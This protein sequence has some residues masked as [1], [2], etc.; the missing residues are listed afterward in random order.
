MKLKVKDVN[1][2]TGGPLIVILNYKDAK[3]LDIHSGDRVL[4]KK[5]RKEIIAALNVSEISRSI[6]HKEIGLLEE[7][8][9][10]LKIKKGEEL[11]LKPTHTPAS[12]EFI[13]KKLDG[14]KLSKKEIKIIVKDMTENDLT[15]VELAYFVSAC[16]KNR[17]SHDEVENLTKAVL[18]N[19]E[20]IKLGKKIIA[21]KHCLGGI[22]NNRTTMLITPI[23]AAAGLTIAKSSSRSITSAAGTADTMEVLSKIA[24]T[25]E[26]IKKIV[27]KANGC[28]IWGGAMELAG[29]DDKLIKVRYPLRLDPEGLMISSILAKK[30]SVGST[31]VLIDIPIGETAKINSKKKAKSLKRKF[32]H[33]GKRLGMN[34]KV[35]ITD[36]SQPIGNGIGPNLE[37][38]DVLYILRRDKKAPKDLEKKSIMMADKI[39]K[40]TKTKASAKIILESGL[41][42]TKMKEII[43][44]QN[45]KSSIK[46]EDIELAKYSYNVKSTRRGKVSFID[47]KKITKVARIAGAP[48]DKR[49]GVYLYK[50]LKTKVKK[51]EILYTI[52]SDSEDKLKYAK[53]I[54]KDSVK[55]S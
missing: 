19:G 52:Y 31:H 26:K 2:S 43:R 48:E 50:H 53:A 3:K 40:L 15:D 22:P 23:L 49:A 46:P 18:E 51:N 7:V 35:I 55:I 41:A 5:G 21:D 8:M 33:L 17:L 16:Y 29:A 38:R 25:P 36:G 32:I 13:R 1:L 9:E 4:L 10:V 45:G 30:A 6:K 24:F 14:E 44:L 47:N 42:Y 39:F 34:I 27:K 28:I 12:I 54:S 20:K 37:A 11:E